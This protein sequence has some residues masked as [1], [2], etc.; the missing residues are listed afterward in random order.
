MI[1]TIRPWF[2]PVRGLAVPL[3]S[4]PPSAARRRPVPPSQPAPRL[5]A[6]RPGNTIID[7]DA[8]PVV[9]PHLVAHEQHQRRQAL[10]FALDGVNVGAEGIHGGYA[11]RL[12]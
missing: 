11:G 3:T 12:A 10:A 7:S 4:R 1:E 5:W 2:E 6:C 9:R 8:R